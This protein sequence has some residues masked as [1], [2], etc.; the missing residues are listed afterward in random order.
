MPNNRMPNPDWNGK[1]WHENRVKTA[2]IFQSNSIAFTRVANALKG[3]PILPPPAL[4]GIGGEDA[5]TRTREKK[6]IAFYTP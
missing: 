3:E 4:F 5:K 2:M 1:T 6:I